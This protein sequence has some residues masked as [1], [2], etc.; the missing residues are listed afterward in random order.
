MDRR[1]EQRT[2]DGWTFRESVPS[3]GK[4]TRLMLLL[5]GWTG[6]ENSMWVFANGF[7]LSTWMIAPRA[8]Y[9]AERKGY[10]WRQMRPGTWGWPTFE[11]LRPAA[12]ALLSWL[13]ALMQHRGRYFETFDVMGFSQG[14][15]LTAVLLAIAPRRIGKAALL[16]GFLPP[17][18]ASHLDAVALSGRAIFMAHGRADQLVSFERA[19]MLADALDAVGADVQFCAHAQGHKV[20]ATCLQVMKRYFGI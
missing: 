15:A 19:E 14:A 9:R 7:P 8:P 5:H 20:N 11:E 18:T 13:D 17:D 6:D 4:P 12:E 2:W 1:T 10:S 16:S 3:D